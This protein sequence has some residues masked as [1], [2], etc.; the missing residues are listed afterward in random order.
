MGLDAVVYC[1]CFEAGRLRTPP[2]HGVE[3]YVGDDGSL[4]CRGEC[5][6]AALVFDAWCYKEACDHENGVLLHRRL[7][8]ISLVGLLREELGHQAK[9]FPALLSKVLYSGTHCGDW[10]TAEE[11]RTVQMELGQL[12]KHCCE[13]ARAQE[14]VDAFRQQMEELVACSLQVGKPIVF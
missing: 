12:K 1:S 4:D 6:E 14:L 2:P 9:A 11:V 3:V 7:G 10:L 5:P 13:S 8:N